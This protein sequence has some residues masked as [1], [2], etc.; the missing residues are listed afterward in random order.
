MGNEEEICAAITDRLPSMVR[1][2][3]RGSISF[4][5]QNHSRHRIG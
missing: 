2:A 4:L 5:S 3:R 1:E